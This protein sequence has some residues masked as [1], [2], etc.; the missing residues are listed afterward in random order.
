MPDYKLVLKEPSAEEKAHLENSLNHF[1][2]NLTGIPFGGDV[3][4]LV[5]DDHE[6]VVGGVNGWQ[7]GDSFE[8]GFLWLEQEWRGQDIGTQLIRSLEQQATGRGCTQIH[9]DTYSF[10][11]IDFYL[12]LG[13]EVVGTLDNF[14]TPHKRYFLKKNLPAR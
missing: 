3:A 13:Y 7:W 6:H 2:M 9:L 10:Q 11:A 14:P 5:Y 8:V 12:K 1:N 4:V